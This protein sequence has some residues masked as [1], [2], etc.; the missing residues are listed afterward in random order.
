PR[1]N[2]THEL[3]THLAASM[4]R[5]NRKMHGHETGDRADGA[6]LTY[7]A[8]RSSKMRKRSKRHRV[9]MVCDF[10]YPRLG[11]VEMHIWS[12]SQC[13]LRRGHRVVVITHGYDNRKGVRYMTNGLKVYYVPLVP[14]VDGDCMP[15]ACA[16]FPIFRQILIRERITLVHG[17]QASSVM[18]HEA[19][20]FAKTMGYRV[21][22][23]DHSLFGFADAASIHLNKLMKF[24]M[25]SVDHAIC[26]SNTCRENLVVRATLPPEKI[27]TIPNAIDPSKF[28]P[29]PS[30]RFPKGTINVVIMSR[31]VYRKGIDLV[32]PVIMCERYPN[33]HFIIGG[34]GPKRLLLEEMREKSQLHDR[35]EILGAV[36][37]ARVRSVLVRGHIFLNCSLTESFCIAILEAASCGLFVVSTA[38]GGVPEVLPGPMIK[39]AEPTVEDLTDALSD[40]I[41]LARKAVPSEFH[42]KVRDMYSWADVAE[43]TERAYERALKAP[44]PSLVRRF[45]AYRRVGMF[46]QAVCCF[47]AAMLHLLWRLLERI[48]PAQDIELAPE[49]PSARQASGFEANPWAPSKARPSS[50]PASS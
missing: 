8:K 10:F 23:T 45:Q 42:A 29:D 49:F 46:G 41:P 24:T 25:C 47:L 39:F 31:L 32:A 15:T 19:I 50:S 3:R 44:P 26:V 7:N 37:H 36:P 11:G 38:V 12:L 43:R 35:V 33:L 27:S 16:F 20:L 21:A 22:Y 2:S 28:T 30:A 40:A 6:E 18:S 48:W 34:D 9:C 13:L 4:E 17:H 1:T 14:V 5:D